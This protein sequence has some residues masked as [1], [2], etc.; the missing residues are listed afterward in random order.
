[1]FHSQLGRFC[2]RDPAGYEDCVSFYEYVWDSPTN[3]MD[4]MG[5]KEIEGGL[6]VEW[7]LTNSFWRCTTG[8]C[9]WPFQR[10]R[11][12]VT[13][14]DGCEITNY[15]A[16][17]HHRSR[18]LWKEQFKIIGVDKI[19]VDDEKC[20]NSCGRK[21]QCVKADVAN[22]WFASQLSYVP[23][24]GSIWVQPGIWGAKKFLG[25]ITGVYLIT[26][27]TVTVCADGSIKRD[28]SNEAVNDPMDDWDYT[29]TEI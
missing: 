18:M 12:T 5:L 4:P 11:V 15:R 27:I 14:P 10:N 22:I 28:A 3:G 21:L 24:P 19:E 8:W 17:F 1:M 16:N 26:R 9:G 29:T 2:S 23:I 6:E 25:S 13:T 20:Q 7:K